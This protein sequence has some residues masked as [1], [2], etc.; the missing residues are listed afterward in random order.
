MRGGSPQVRDA[1]RLGAGCSPVEPLT[2]DAADV[3]YQEYWFKGAWFDELEV[4]CRNLTAPGR[5]ENRRY[6]A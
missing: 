1:V 6:A 5:L 4:Y 2:T 3:S